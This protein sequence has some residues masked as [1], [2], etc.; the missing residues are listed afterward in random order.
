MKKKFLTVVFIVAI[1]LIYP[2]L[3]LGLYEMLYS[4]TKICLSDF[5]NY[6]PNTLT[7]IVSI[8]LSYYALNVSLKN[9]KVSL[10]ASKSVIWNFITRSCKGFKESSQKKYYHYYRIKRESFDNHLKRL[11]NARVLNKNDEKLCNDIYHYVGKIEDKQP[12]ND[13]SIQITD[14]YNEFWN[15]NEYKENVK[16]VLDKLEESSPDD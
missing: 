10:E 14:V 11:V 15:G 4:S 13:T 5:F 1:Y 3:A 12:Q 16:E 8:F 9:E 7:G 2:Y 6:L